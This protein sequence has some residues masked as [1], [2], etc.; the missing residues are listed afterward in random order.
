[1][2]ISAVMDGCEQV[3]A[4]DGRT[5]EGRSHPVIQLVAVQPCNQVI[6]RGQH[7]CHKHGHL[8]FSRT[9]C[10]DR[11]N[12]PK[13]DATHQARWGHCS[14]YLSDIAS[15]VGSLEDSAIIGM[16]LITDQSCSVPRSAAPCKIWPESLLREN[17]ALTLKPNFSNVALTR[18]LV[19]AARVHLL[20]ILCTH[21]DVVSACCIAKP[22]ENDLTISVVTHAVSKDCQPLCSDRS[23]CGYN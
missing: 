4:D 9:T 7:T 21:E 20:M 2:A 1:M 3:R 10:M 11:L 19:P 22:R 23:R 15:P 6:Y 5:H 14:I 17:E 12:V 16:L 13:C 18:G 8:L